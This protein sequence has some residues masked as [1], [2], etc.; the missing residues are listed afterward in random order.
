[1]GAFLVNSISIPP[2]VPIKMERAPYP[3]S[4]LD[5]FLHLGNF[6]PYVQSF[7][8]ELIGIFVF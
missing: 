6:A 8:L 1:M 3:L 7:D 5:R 4:L 2:K